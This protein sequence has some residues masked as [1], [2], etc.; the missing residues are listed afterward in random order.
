MHGVMKAC[1]LLPT[2]LHNLI[3]AAFHGW[4]KA[5]EYMINTTKA[6]LFPRQPPELGPFDLVTQSPSATLCIPCWTSQP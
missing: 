3:D 5:I 2:S 6:I 1:K 4:S